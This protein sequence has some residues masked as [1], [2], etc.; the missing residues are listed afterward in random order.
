VDR[1][2]TSSARL[3]L[4]A[5][6]SIKIRLMI[7]GSSSFDGM[8]CSAHSRATRAATASCVL[9]TWRPGEAID[10]HL[11]PPGPCLA[12]ARGEV[13]TGTSAEGALPGWDVSWQPVEHGA[14]SGQAADADQQEGPQRAHSLI[15]STPMV[16]VKQDGH[17]AVTKRYTH[18][19]RRY[20][21]YDWDVSSSASQVVSRSVSGVQTAVS[22]RHQRRTRGPLG[23]IR[24]DQRGW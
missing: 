15:H 12:A 18:C 24:P 8:P 16:Q 10:H 3:C 20:G 14:T 11:S 21:Q 4:P 5:F 2:A 1:V 19:E 13:L 23:K 9:V 6:I 22:A 7:A 17:P